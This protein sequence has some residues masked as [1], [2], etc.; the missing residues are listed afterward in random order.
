MAITFTYPIVAPKA[1]DLIIGTQTPDPLSSETDTPT[2]NFTIQ[3]IVDLVSTTSFVTIG[4]SQTIT[5]AKTFT[6]NI[7]A[8]NVGGNNT[9]DQSLSIS[10]SVITISGTNSTVTVPSGGIVSSLSTSGTSG[11]ATLSSAGVLNI[12]NYTNA[13]WNLAGDAGTPQSIADG[14]TASL[15]GLNGITT[16]I[17]GVNT[18]KIQLDNT[19]VTPGSYTHASVTVDQ[20][21]RLTA[22]SSGIGITAQQATDITN[23]VKNDTD[24]YTSTPSVTKI[25]TLTQAQYTAITTPDVY[26]LYIII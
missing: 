10:G 4:G 18:L 19:A 26:T 8:P 23:S 12:P 22:V 14:D 2:R 20:Q 7:A 13:F 11:A 9:G 1:D 6:T 25:I 5:G 3:S 17:Y 15:Q 21:G 24:T 16:S